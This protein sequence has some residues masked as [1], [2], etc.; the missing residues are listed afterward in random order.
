VAVIFRWIVCSFTPDSQSRISSGG[1]VRRDIDSNDVAFD[2][3]SP[4]LDGDEDGNC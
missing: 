1:I 4:D 2:V 3:L